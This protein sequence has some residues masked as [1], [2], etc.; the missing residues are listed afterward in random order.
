MFQVTKLL[1]LLL[2]SRFVSISAKCDS[3][4]FCFSPD[5]SA[6]ITISCLKQDSLISLRLDTLGKTPSVVQFENNVSQWLL[7]PCC[8]FDFRI[9]PI[10]FHVVIQISELI[11][12]LISNSSNKR[13][14]AMKIQHRVKRISIRTHIL[15][16]FRLAVNHPCQQAVFQNKASFL[17]LG[18]VKSDPF[19]IQ[20]ICNP[21]VEGLSKGF[22]RILVKT[23]GEAL[24][25]PTHLR[26][27]YSNSHAS[28]MV[29]LCS[30]W[31]PLRK[32]RK[33]PLQRSKARRTACL[34]PDPPNFYFPWS[35]LC[36]RLHV[37]HTL[38]Y[39]LHLERYWIQC[40]VLDP[41]AHWLWSHFF[42]SG[43]CPATEQFIEASL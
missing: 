28:R 9:K 30:H 39:Q 8:H 6:N 17:K 1:L 31:I 13:H 25:I 34:V 23:H 22:K 20:N 14:Y 33:G 35:L 27:R 29:V 19:V 40:L 21:K 10:R 2:S 37:L 42:L 12:I 18:S 5:P 32:I 36:L 16:R 24:D 15:I 41:V 43:S 4:S 26:K 11:H 38:V 7:S 3:N